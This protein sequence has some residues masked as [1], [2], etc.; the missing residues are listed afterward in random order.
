[1][2]LTILGLA[3]E[4]YWEQQQAQ[5]LVLKVELGQPEVELGQP[6]E[7]KENSR[8][9]GFL[10]SQ[11]R[12]GWVVAQIEETLLNI[13]RDKRCHLVAGLFWWEVMREGINGKR[14]AGW[15]YIAEGWQERGGLEEIGYLSAWSGCGQ[16]VYPSGGRGVGVG[17]WWE[18]R[19]A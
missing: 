9:R 4:H 12:F 16:G 5:N 8:N 11:H 1:M 13:V 7:E 6:E 18:D 14:P 15:L 3:S 19:E 17:G 10:I 2:D